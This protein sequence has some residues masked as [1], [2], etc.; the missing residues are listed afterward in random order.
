MFNIAQNTFR[1]IIR[2]KLL[3]VIVFF[4]AVFTVFSIL[5]D[6]LT[7][8]EGNKVI[9]DFWL[10]MIEVFWLITVL[11]VWSQLLFKEIE[12]KTIFLILSKPIRRYEFILGKFFGFSMV[13][14]IITL[15]Q[16]L[17]FFGVLWYMEI[18]LQS[19]VLI[20]I[21]FTFF[22]LEILLALVFFFSTFM[23][24]I[25]TILV[26]MMIYVIGHSYSLVLDLI[27]TVKTT[28]W[29]TFVKIFGVLIPPF[30]ALN[31]KDV[32]GMFSEYTPEY[33]LLNS[34]Y[35]VIYLMIVLFLAVIIFERKTFER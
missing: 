26:T 22:K 5:L 25:L 6:G 33:F 21:V 7:L 18:P 1:E 35:S 34:M 9:V 20:S 15:F 16:A 32:I 19:L 24:T 31:T 28:V 13:I 12:G 17:V 30:E 23:S 29:L 2:N 10:A 4:A 3:Y 14:A 8:G 27:M 11:F